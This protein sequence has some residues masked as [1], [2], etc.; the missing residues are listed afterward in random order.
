LISI[1]SFILSDKSVDRTI[2]RSFTLRCE[3]TAWKLLHLPVI[4]DA[5]T[6]S[7]LAV[8]GLIGTG[9]SGFVFF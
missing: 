2:I 5:L 9:A 1:A 7:S 6:A 4:G 8:T 3:E